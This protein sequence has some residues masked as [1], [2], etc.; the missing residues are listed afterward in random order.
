MSKAY[1][2]IVTYRFCPR[3]GGELWEVTE[4]DRAR[5]RALSRTPI[6]PR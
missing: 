1:K 4:Y 2:Q 6:R 5:N 3:E